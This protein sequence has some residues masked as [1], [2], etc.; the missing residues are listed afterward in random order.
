[1]SFITAD[2]LN[3]N[4]VKDLIVTDF[5]KSGNH[6]DEWKQWKKIPVT[7]YNLLVL[8][9]EAGEL[10]TGWSKQWDMTKTHSDMEAHK[11][12]LAFEA[13]Q[14]VAW[15]VGDRTVV[16]SIPPY[17]G[18][19]WIKDKYILHEQQGPFNAG[20]P[21]GSWVFPWQSATCSQNFTDVHVWIA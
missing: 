2:D 21:V 19:E 20:P 14:L 15:K 3:K 10:K 16:E 1:M 18:L 7:N 6:I 8:E 12:F 5:G 13:K 4:G 11:Y 17:L 9:W